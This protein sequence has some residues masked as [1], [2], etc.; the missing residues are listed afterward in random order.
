MSF[1]DL[2][3]NSKKKLADLQKQIDKMNKPTYQSDERFWRPTTDKSGNGSAIIRFLDAPENETCP[4][5]TYYEHNFK[6]PTG[7]IY[8]EKSLTSLNKPDPCT[9]F[10]TELWNTNTE[11]NQN[12][13]RAQ[14]RH[15]RYVSNILVLKDPANPENEGKVFLYKYGV[16][17]FNKINELLYPEAIDED[18]VV[19]PV[20]PFDFWEGCNFRMKI[21]TV[22]KYYNYDSSKFDLPKPLFG[23]DD[24]KIE[25]VYKKQHS[26]QAFVAPESF[27]SY[28]EL[29]KRLHDVL[30]TTA[31]VE[32]SVSKT[33]K[34]ETE[35]DDD[36]DVPYDTSVNESVEDDDL[37][38]EEFES[39]AALVED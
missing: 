22:D 28:E 21:T 25:E 24:D 12:R 3:K 1:K 9:E 14:K 2:K 32:S 11:E 8:S 31:V 36:D 39:L 5:V 35:D 37:D 7:K 13:A 20:N 33:S 15:Q 4:W 10:N 17:I 18:D 19:E 27:K 34:E 23:G 26:L 30:G 6:G 16:K 29:E 38:S